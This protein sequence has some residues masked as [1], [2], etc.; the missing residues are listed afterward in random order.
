MT[1]EQALDLAEQRL[2][3]RKVRVPWFSVAVLVCLVLAG[4]AIVLLIQQV[5]HL[6]AR[7]DQSSKDRTTQI[8]ALSTRVDRLQTALTGSQQQVAYLN[9]VNATKDVRI[10][11][12]TDELLRR[13]IPVPA[14]IVT[15]PA[16]PSPASTSRPIPHP[17][18]HPRPRPTPAPRPTPRPSPTPSPTPACLLP[19]LPICVH[20]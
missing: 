4:V 20:P 18:P 16:S 8:D 7:I 1:A 6:Q 9:A 5:G 3:K 15:A 12:L 11:Q 14:P 10:R 19:R 17:T 2:A 13:G